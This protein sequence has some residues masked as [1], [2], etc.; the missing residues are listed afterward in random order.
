[1]ACKTLNHRSRDQ[2]KADTLDPLVWSE[3]ALNSK[4]ETETITKLLNILASLGFDIDAFYFRS[5]LDHEQNSVNIYGELGFANGIGFSSHDRKQDIFAAIQFHDKN[6]S[7]SCE[8][9]YNSK[10]LRSIHLTTAYIAEVFRVR[11]MV[12]SEERPKL[13]VRE[14][15]C[16][17]WS[18]IGYSTKKIADVLNLADSTVN[19]YINSAMHKLNAST[20]TQACAR[21]FLLKL[22]SP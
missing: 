21:A 6:N 20:R 16:L 19:E 22:I 15:E 11:E 17:T 1:M 13:S 3:I 7:D 9:P 14:E 5:A 4:N 8:K 10:T 18:A 2:G 12:R